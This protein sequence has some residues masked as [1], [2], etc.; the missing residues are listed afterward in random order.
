MAASKNLR[1]SDADNGRGAILGERGRERERVCERKRGRG[2]REERDGRESGD[3]DFHSFSIVMRATRG[4]R[5][6][7][8]FGGSCNLSKKRRRAISRL[9]SSNTR[10]MQ[11][12][13]MQPSAAAA[14]CISSNFEQFERSR[15]TSPSEAVS[16]SLVHISTLCKCEP[17]ASV[18]LV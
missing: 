5:I 7:R 2:E 10:H 9:A 1:T 17:F 15:A 12:S 14:V 6:S 11:P 18:F 3:G 8:F 16:V 13:A 4:T